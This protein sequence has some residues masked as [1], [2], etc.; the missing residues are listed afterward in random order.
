MVTFLL[1]KAPREFACVLLSDL[2]EDRPMTAD[3]LEQIFDTGDESCQVSICLRPDLSQRLEDKCRN[4]RNEQVL[5][6]YLARVQ[7]SRMG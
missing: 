4:S 7:Y 6:H 5:E 1:A 2:A 3:L